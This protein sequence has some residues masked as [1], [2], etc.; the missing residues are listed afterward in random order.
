MTPNLEGANGATNE[1]I[2][3]LE[4]QSQLERYGYLFM[5]LSGV[6]LVFL[7]ITHMM[8]QHVLNDV[9]DLSL[10]FVRSVWRSWGWR[11]FDLL[12]LIL[13]T[14]HG[15]NG[16]RVVLEDYVHSPRAV[17]ILRW[18]LTVFLIVTVIWSA[19]AILTFDAGMPD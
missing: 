18:I 7:A 2:V 4:S 6:A 3:H 1:R 14:T 15:F 8:I 19:V 11:I 13:A 9:H 10:A 5:R 16:L 12:M 17:E